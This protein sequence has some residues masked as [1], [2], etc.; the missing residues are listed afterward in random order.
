MVHYLCYN[1]VPLTYIA[2]RIMGTNV[3]RTI[4]DSR[5]CGITLSFMNSKQK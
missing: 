2:V 4:I 3:Y 1:Y 5:D